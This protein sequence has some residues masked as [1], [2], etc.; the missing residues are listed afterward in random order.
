V[1]Q[2]KKRK[3]EPEETPAAVEQKKL[4]QLSGAV[5][6]SLTNKPK[7]K[8]PAN[9]PANA[10]ATVYASLFTSSINQPQVKESFLCRNV[11]RG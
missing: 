2:D 10:T 7:E 8:K 9:V 11:S 6:L 4:K 3:K 1:K 5:D